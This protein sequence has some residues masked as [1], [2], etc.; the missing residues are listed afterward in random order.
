[1]RIIEHP[2]VVLLDTNL[3]INNIT[4]VYYGFRNC[5]SPDE[6]MET[7]LNN[8]VTEQEM[9]V[10]IKKMRKSPHESPLEHAS[11]TFRISDIS[12]N[13]SHQ[14]VRHRLASMSQSS[15][16]YIK[17][18]E[19]TPI[20]I[21]TTILNNES[22]TKLYLQNVQTCLNQY[23]TMI[24]NGIPKEDARFILPSCIATSIVMTMNFRELI[25][26]FHERL[27]Y[28]AQWEIREVANQMFKL[29]IDKYPCIFENEGP[30]CISLGKCPEYKPCAYAPYKV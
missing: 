25:H 1:M 27:C 14:I 17:L 9:V 19:S 4:K 30:K 15:Q 18:D 5:Y 28:R 29:C 26:F 2:K 8:S 10:F 24:I 20:V 23:E 6:V 3:A 21:P 22:E 11:L 16:R 12:R 13:C 7:E